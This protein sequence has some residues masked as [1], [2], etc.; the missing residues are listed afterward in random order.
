MNKKDL[1][2]IYK[3]KR[4]A[5]DQ[6]TIDSLSLK[7][8]H[9]TLEL[10]VWEASFYHLFLTIKH[11]KEVETEPLMG[12]LFGK[13]KNVVVPKSNISTCEMTHYLLTDNTT[14]KPN[15][16]NIPEPQNGV[17][18]QTDQIQVVFVPLLAFDSTGH[19]VGYGKGFYD[20]FLKSCPKA[21][22]I[23]LSFFDAVDKIEDKTKNDIPLDYCV[24]PTQ[25]YHFF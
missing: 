25:I 22:K 14:I 10:P 17:E 11:L 15:I 12:I 4:R 7:I 19:R 24:T 18:I 8:A 16:W 9:Q 23:G 1:R 20:L 21:I 3:Q 5:L 2:S 13:D 6:S